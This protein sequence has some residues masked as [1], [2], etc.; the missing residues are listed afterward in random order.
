MV[1]CERK[2]DLDEFEHGLNRM[3]H[4]PQAKFR[5]KNFAVVESDFLSGLNY[6]KYERKLCKEVRVSY[7]T[8]YIYGQD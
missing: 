1:P 5:A 7:I 3:T 2:A 8:G 6:Y 4:Y